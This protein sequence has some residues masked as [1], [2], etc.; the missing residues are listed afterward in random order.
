MI[1]INSLDNSKFR[2]VMETLERIGVPKNKTK[3]FY[4]ICF[5]LRIYNHYFIAHYKEIIGQPLDKSDIAKLHSVTTLLQRWGH[6]KILDESIAET[7]F[8]KLKVL[9]HDEKHEWEIKSVINSAEIIEFIAKQK[10]QVA[11]VINGPIY[12]P[13]I[14]LTIRKSDQ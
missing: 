13:Y 11:T 7:K 8:D 3:I 14:P 4:Q 2:I 9:K 5:V 6:I 12:Y 1:E 10:Q